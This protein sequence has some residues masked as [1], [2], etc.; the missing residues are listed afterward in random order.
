VVTD[1]LSRNIPETV[2]LVTSFNPRQIKNAQKTDPKTAPLL[3][4]LGTGK[5]PENVSGR[6]KQSVRDASS[7]FTVTRGVLFRRNQSSQGRPLVVV[8]NDLQ[9]HAMFAF[10]DTV[11]SMHMGVDKTES[12]MLVVRDATGCSRV[13][14]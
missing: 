10:H 12:S 14:S 6:Q 3:Q 4:Y 2:N 11:S 7:K 8:P 13:L 9:I 1:V 5:L